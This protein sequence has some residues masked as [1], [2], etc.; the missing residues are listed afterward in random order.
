MIANPSHRWF[1]RLVLGRLWSLSS[2]RQDVHVIF[3]L[4][5]YT[6]FI[7][8]RCSCPRAASR[9]IIAVDLLT[10][11]IIRWQGSS[12]MLTS[13]ALS[14]FV[15]HS[16]WTSWL[17]YKLIGTMWL[18]IKPCPAAFSFWN[19]VPSSADHVSTVS[20]IAQKRSGGLKETYSILNTHQ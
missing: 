1:S 9:V 20:L 8:I 15:A 3:Y 2:L 13:T 7:P 4:I 12:K 14:W 16:S 11:G 6:V 17:H 5:T 18:F 19:V 10:F